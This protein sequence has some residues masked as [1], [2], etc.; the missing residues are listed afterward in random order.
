MC[1]EFVAECASCDSVG[2]LDL[3]QRFALVEELL[4]LAGSEMSGEPDAGGRG[5]CCGI[6]ELA[7]VVAS[8][9]VQVLDSDAEL[10]GRVPD[11]ALVVDGVVDGARVD[12]V[13]IGAG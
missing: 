8:D 13:W 7:R 6:V 3:S 1:D 4:E 9:V 12:R 11:R 5:R 2:G 10:D